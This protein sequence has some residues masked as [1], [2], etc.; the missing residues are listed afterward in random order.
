MSVQTSVKLYVLALLKVMLWLP[1]RLVLVSLSHGEPTAG[2]LDL[3][4]LASGADVV[5][6]Q[7][8]VELLPTFRLFGEDVRVTVGLGGKAIG[9]LLQACPV[10]VWN[11][12]PL[13][14]S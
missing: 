3:T 10:G 6:V 9:E 8:I 13:N 7:L 12:K 4:Q 5:T 11:T 14:V 1:V 2:E